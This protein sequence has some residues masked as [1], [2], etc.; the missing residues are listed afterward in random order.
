MK[1]QKCGAE[2]V[3]GHLYCDICGAEYQIVP[4][5]E[6][7][8][9]FSIAESLSN[10]SETIE[11]HTDHPTEEFPN[12][13]P[14][15][16]KF[17]VPAFST[18]F[19]LVFVCFAFIYAGYYKYT[20]SVEYRNTKALEAISNYDYYEAAQIYKSLRKDNSQDAYW[21]IKEADTKLMLNKTTEA[22]NL[23][24]LAIDLEEN[25]DMAYEFL[26]SFLEEQGNYI[27]M[28]QLLK[29]CG[30]PEIKEKY[31]EYLCEVPKLNYESGSYDTSLELIFEEGY[32]GNIY[33]TLD[34]TIPNKDSIKYEKPIQ[35]GN[36]THILTVIYETS[37]GSFSE[38]VVYEY[39]IDS[40]VP[41][42][43]LVTLDS[44]TYSYAEMIE[45]EIEQGTKVYYTTDLTKPTEQSMEYTSPIPMP[46]GESQFKF[47]AYSSKGVV[48]KVTHKKY[49][50][51]IKV[52]ISAED[53]AIFLMQELINA[54]HILNFN[55]S[56]P[57]RYG[58][59]HYFYKY[60]ISEAGKNYYVY[61]EHYLENQINNPLNQF[62]AV[63][64]LTGN[65]YKLILENDGSFT[66]IEF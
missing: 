2:M 33:Y 20:H 63:D 21:Y 3:S 7:E 46:L 53:A 8:I 61:E 19:F 29:N 49:N 55:G 44:G 40:L 52:N 12:P 23:A 10:I 65:A 11:N 43:P 54:G 37:F 14:E 32:E 64:V 51:D 13:E 60:T 50:L 18:I 6:P 22:Y 31:W 34:K 15:Q 39:Q 48:S 41:L 35:L 5:F 45:V 1:C 58:V 57:D 17:K 26:L 66:R 62:Y 4:D 38:P 24:L 25:S 42:A 27:E 30:Y 56:I 9:E 36:G 47:V 16:T 28:N 59:F